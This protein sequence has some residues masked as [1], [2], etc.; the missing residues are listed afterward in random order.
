MVGGGVF[1]DEIWYKFLA[2]I[3]VLALKYWD[4]HVKIV[5]C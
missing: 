3:S 1:S 2:T 5:T 4:K